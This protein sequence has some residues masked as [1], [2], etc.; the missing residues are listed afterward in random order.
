MSHCGM[1]RSSQQLR[2]DA[3][4]IWRAGVAAVHPERLIPQYVRVAGN[5]LCIGD[6]EFNLPALERI[7]IVGAGKAGAS[8][9]IA[10]ETALGDELLKAKQVTGWVNV[11]ADCLQST[12]CVHLHPAR[13][14]AINEPTPAGLQGTSQ[15]LELVANLRAGD[16][17]LC[18][19]SGGGSA[20]LPAPIDGL[21]LAAKVQLTRDISARGGTIGQLNTIRRE[22]SLVKGGGLA[23]AC[24]AGHLVTLILSDVPGDDLETIASGPT[25]ARRPT[26]AA[27]W[28]VMQE[29][30]LPDSAATE[31]VKRAL[32]KPIEPQPDVT[33]QVTHVLIGNNA[34]AV[35]AAGVAAER[36][37][38][39]H[40]MISS[41]KP[42]ATAEEVAAGLV[43]MAQAM[44]EHTGPDCLIS[45]GEPTVAL[46]PITE[47]GLGGRNLQLALSALASLEN[48]Q[49][50]ALLSGGTDGEDGPTDAAGA[51]VSEDVVARARDMQ[52][53]ANE[54]LRRNDAYHF[55]ESVDGLLKT[56][57]THTN[58]CDMRVVTVGSSQG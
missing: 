51:V 7:A 8:M 37:G 17:C 2:D 31:A 24:R 54:Y 29:L 11:P 48:W 21:P 15:I 47:R 41:T 13:P 44:R 46:A 42:E 26:P 39:S 58:V 6:Q 40:A 18:V 3:E 49:N 14:A 52:I 33:A 19:I 57:P 25:V 16:L 35:D 50:L 10:L 43:E 5:R 27:A 36:L 28:Q 23:R 55:F 38:Y 53:D 34:T 9:A 4:Q 22:L 45:G 56:G 30:G 32:T 20:L 12:R 1:E